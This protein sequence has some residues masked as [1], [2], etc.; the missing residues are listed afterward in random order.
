M[1]IPGGQ[2]MLAKVVAVF[3]SKHFPKKLL[4]Q[5]RWAFPKDL[6]QESTDSL[7]ITC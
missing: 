4:E 2:G 7:T 3:R 6:V 5:R 1:A